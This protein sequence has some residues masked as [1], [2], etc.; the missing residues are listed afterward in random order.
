MIDRD[1]K[2][3]GVLGFITNHG[4]LDNPTFRGMRWQLMHSFD[5]I[6]VLDLHGNSK[7]KEVCPDGSPDKNVFDLQQG[8]A[9]HAAG[10]PLL[11]GQKTTTLAER[12]QREMWRSQGVNGAAR[13]AGPRDGCE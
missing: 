9:I 13:C 12:T 4:Y 1:G 2:G 5:R 7:K 3:E 6:H 10:K 8:V 11:D